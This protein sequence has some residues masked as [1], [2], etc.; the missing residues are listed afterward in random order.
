MKFIDV[1]HPCGVCM[2]VSSEGGAC[3]LGTWNANL[4]QCGK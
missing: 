1:N 2:A 3:E 4:Q